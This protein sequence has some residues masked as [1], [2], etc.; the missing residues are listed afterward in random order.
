MIQGW[1][2]MQNAESD[3]SS[4]FHGSRRQALVGGEDPQPDC[5]KCRWNR[6]DRPTRAEVHH[7]QT[8]TAGEQPSY[9]R[10]H[11]DSDDPRLCMMLDR[12]PPQ[13]VGAFCHHIQPT[14]T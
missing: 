6:A 4:A 11:S 9:P 13:T 7:A 1:R 8:K 5:A 3:T 12:D 14:P 10:L 2:K